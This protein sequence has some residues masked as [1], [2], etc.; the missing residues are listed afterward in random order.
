M[1][2]GLGTRLR[3]LT[4]DCPKPMLP[5]AGKPLL[6]NILEGFIASGFH[7]FYISVH[8]LADVIKKHFGDGER[9]G[10]TIRYIE[11]DR[12]LG[13]AG[14]LGLLPSVDHL[15]LIVM[16]GDLLTRVDFAELLDFHEGQK[17]E[18]TVGVREYE[19]QVPFGVIRSEG[20]NVVGIVEKPIQRFF[21]NAGIYV[22]SP[23]LVHTVA[24]GEHL[25]MPDL[26][27]QVLDRQSPVAM[28]PIHEY[29]LDIGRPDD[30]VRAQLDYSE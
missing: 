10:I 7:R 23:R 20:Q 11:E 5:V 6:Q 25:D 14:A 29:W 15:P 17:A 24:A 12:P 1:A 19:M 26:I 13:T 22:L 4:E 16:N 3:P 18:V 28:Y 30:F 9:W 8:Y 27:Q 21:V 2:G